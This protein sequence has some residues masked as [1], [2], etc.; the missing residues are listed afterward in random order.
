M[1]QDQNTIRRSEK[2]SGEQAAV[3]CFKARAKWHHCLG[4]G[5]FSIDRDAM[6]RHRK[7]YSRNIRP[8]TYIPLYVKAIALAIQRNP[9]ANAMLF[10]NLFGLRIVQFEKIDV[11]LPITRMIGDR[12][13]TFIGT[14][15]NAAAKSL[16]QIQDE[17]IKYQRC[18]PD[19]SFAIRRFQRFAR[20]PLWKMR[21]VQWRMT[22]SPDFY[23]RNIG[24]CGVTFLEGD[25]NEYVF[26][27]APMGVVLGIGGTRP[28][29]IIRADTVTTAR[30]LKCTLMVDNYIISG[31]TAFRLVKDFKEVLESGSMVTEELAQ[32]KDRSVVR[33]GSRWRKRADDGK[34]TAV[35]QGS[36]CGDNE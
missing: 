15:R 1:T 7:E 4:Y 17:L 34:S 6:Q 18:E 12:A 22:R 32:W 27:I 24:T 16:A 11:N 31:S 20:M 2:L 10:K 19:D 36:P 35:H 23:I 8:I 3:Y 25:W 28:E 9:E 29:A 14:V 33:E 30:A 5:T 21:F 13:V 26:P